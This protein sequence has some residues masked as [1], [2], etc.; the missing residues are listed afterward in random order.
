VFHVTGDTGHE[1]YAKVVRAILLGEGISRAPRGHATTDLGLTV[2]EMPAP[3]QML[4]LGT[5]PN[6]SVNLG[7]V[8]AIQLIGGFTNMELIKAKAPSLM[9]FSEE[10][11]HF[12]GAYG[13]RIVGQV[14]AQIIKLR[15]D[16]CSRQAVITLHDPHLDNSPGK[17]DY[18]C[19][20]GFQL[21]I[22]NEKLCWTTWMRSNDIHRGLPYDLFQFGQL[23][24]TVARTLELVPGSY[25]HVVTSMHAYA[26][27]VDKLREVDADNARNDFQPLGIGHE[28]EHN[29]WPVMQQMA[30]D[31]CFSHSI[32]NEYL[33]PSER[34]YRDRLYVIPSTNS[35]A[36]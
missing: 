14:N 32:P 4:P 18:P 3:E 19:T 13:K 10:G 5:R 2:I 23:Q 26:S 30:R 16:P 22:R 31:I 28:H 36:I 35:E 8:E 34:W 6:L 20:V 15:D 29:S 7:A 27:D 1:V 12:H 9:P 17:K 25:T 33:T 21:E 24:M 11:K